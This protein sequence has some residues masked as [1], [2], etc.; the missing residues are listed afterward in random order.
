MRFTSGLRWAA[1]KYK[2][3]VEGE[4]QGT[5]PPAIGSPTGPSDS[6]YTRRSYAGLHFDEVTRQS[7]RWLP[8]VVCSAGRLGYT[9]TGPP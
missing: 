6:L 7:L 4:P 8:G 2:P 9:Q 1:G 3:T 5:A